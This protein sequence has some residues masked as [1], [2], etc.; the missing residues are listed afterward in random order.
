MTQGAGREDRTHLIRLVE[1]VLS[2]RTSPAGLVGCL[3]I[4]PRAYLEAAVLQT[5]LRPCAHPEI[6]NRAEVEL[7]N[8]ELALHG[9]TS[10]YLCRESNP[11]RRASEARVSS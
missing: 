5:A 4:E 3:G 1:P 2:Q 6:T 9:A 7:K 10:R 11:D 8:N